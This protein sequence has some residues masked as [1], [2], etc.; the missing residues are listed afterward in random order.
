MHPIVP[1]VD[2]AAPEESE[3]GAEAEAEADKAAT[4]PLAEL[5]P[6]FMD[7]LK[8]RRAEEGQ[9]RKDRDMKR[10]MAIQQQAEAAAEQGKRKKGM[11]SPIAKKKKKKEKEE[12]LDERTK[13]DQD[14]LVWLAGW[15]SCFL[16]P[17]D[18]L[19]LSLHT[20]IHR[21]QAERTGSPE[22]PQPPEHTRNRAGRKALQG[23]NGK[24]GSEEQQACA[25]KRAGGDSGSGKQA[26][27]TGGNASGERKSHPLVHMCL[28]RDQPITEC[29][30]CMYV[31]MY[32]CMYTCLRL[33]IQAMRE[34]YRSMAAEQEQQ[35]RLVV[36]RWA[37]E[38]HKEAED[39]S[40]RAVAQIITIAEAEIEFKEV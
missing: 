17:S 2:E 25:R 19:L 16:P 13:G 33:Q 23:S 38:E 9:A 29:R 27:A 14:F 12:E 24:G 34:R 3:A 5:P 32:V 30:M 4:D 1:G 22:S 15:L 6:D 7:K 37:A 36:E 35:R 21:R 28:S 11:M 18:F 20:Y 8:E 39:L 26:K 10:R 40:R 31:C